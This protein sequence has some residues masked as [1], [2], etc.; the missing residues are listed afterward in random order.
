VWPQLPIFSDQSLKK[1]VQQARNALG[2]A[3][4]EHQYIQTVRGR[5]Y[6]FV[7]AVE[8]REQ[9]PTQDTL[10]PA[11]ALIPEVP[12]YEP[13]PSL[14]VAVASPAVETPPA[15]LPPAE[16]Y[17]RVTVLSYA[18]DEA[19]ALAMRLGPE[20]MHQVMQ[21]V[22][23]H[24]EVVVRRYEGTIV[25]VAGDGFTVLFGAPV[26]QEDHARRA[27]LA[28]LELRQHVL[29]PPVVRLQTPGNPLSARMGVHTG[30]AV[31]G[32]WPH[33]PQRLYTAVGASTHLATRLQHLARPGTILISAATYH[34][35][36]AEVGVEACDVLRD[37]TGLIPAPV[38]TVH[39]VVRRHAGVPGGQA[40]P[41]S[42]FVGR[43]R[44]LTFFH[45]CL[46]QAAQGQ[47]QVVGI[48]GEPGMGKSRLLSELVQSLSARAVVSYTGHCL[49]YGSTTPYLLVRDLLRQ[50]CGLREADTP[51]TMTVHVSRALQQAGIAPAAEAPLLLQLL[52]V[53]VDAASLAQLSPQAR[54]ART[55][56]VLHQLLLCESHRQL[57]VLGVENCHWIDATS[58]EWLM[59]LIERLPG[60]AVLLLAT[61]RPG[62]HPLWLDKSYVTQLALPRLTPHESLVVLQS[63]AQ[64]AALS[65]PLR[66]EIIVKAAGNPFFLEE[67]TRSALEEGGHPAA[68]P[69]PDTIQAVLAARIDRLPPAE[70]QLLQT[71]AVIGKDIPVP[72]LHTITALPEEALYES[73]R[74]LQAAEFLY[75]TSRLPA[76]T[77]TFKHALIQEVASQSLLQ[78]TR[79]HHH[80]QTAQAL[81]ERFPET[82]TTQPELLAY[83]YTEAGLSAQ[84][85]VYWQQAGQRALER[86]AHVEAMAHL[87]KGLEVLQGLPDTPERAQQELEVQTALG[88]ALMATRGYAAP[89]VLHTYA[90]A[91]ALCQQV[92]ATPQLFPVLRGLRAFYVTRAE[93]QTARELAE[94]FLT[95]AQHV[96]DPSALLEANY[97]MGATLYFL[98]EFGPAWTHLRPCVASSDSQRHRSRA[99]LYGAAPRVSCLSYAALTLWVLGHADQALARSREALT[100]AQELSHP[101]SLAFALEMAA[102]L[103]QF[104]QEGHVTQERAEALIA[105]STAQGFTLYQALGMLLQGWA[106]AQHGRVEEGIVRIGQGLAARRTTGAELKRPY[107]LVLLAE[108][109]G[110]AGQVE[111]GLRVL[112]EAGRLVHTTGE[113]RAEAEL[114]RLQGELL[115]QKAAG[116]GSART[117]S[118]AAAAVPEADQ[119]LLSEAETCFRQALDVARRQQAKSLELRAALSLARLWQQQGQRAE[120]R[121]LLAPLYGWFTEGFDTA[122]LQEA[123]ALLEALVG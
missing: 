90:R 63:M 52:D 13:S 29:A 116:R 1:C 51:A 79:Q 94:Q 54:K 78:R 45:Q 122:D 9:T 50:I 86:S 114:S 103:H 81:R 76:V 40:R 37:A 6:R 80:Q 117:R 113:H 83:H 27:V 96:Q 43:R 12:A 47:G 58:E 64:T 98:G 11:L 77:Y 85:L 34:L 30:P 59:A 42:P 33:A 120:A 115:L 35:V 41:L 110:K 66:Q 104:R 109:Y 75:E 10:R 22:V 28:A 14:T 93:L 60:A 71:A 65:E 70:K 49:A 67:L 21:A 17:K 31:V 105:L 108:A 95:V 36:Q 23:A 111:A 2:E 84:A 92:G 99:G 68:L 61:Y 20:A 3:G 74:H 100:L 57:L 38:Y 88:A 119:P 16:E 53:P 106:L 15:A 62:Y 32:H 8:E 123:K 44:E 48:V 46:A 97:A 4:Q 118:V 101:F 55:F 73:L 82:A 87:T 121:A 89:E 72:L 112:A 24:A 69:I 25:H 7:A 26:A 102:W 107:Y 18:V 19:P 39:G 5:G 91:R 56:H